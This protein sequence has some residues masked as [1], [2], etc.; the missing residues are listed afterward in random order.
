MIQMIDV[1]VTEERQR[2]EGRRQRTEGYRKSF[3]RLP[4]GLKAPLFFCQSTSA[5]LNQALLYQ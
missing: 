1:G 4:R 3:L 2:A 5:F